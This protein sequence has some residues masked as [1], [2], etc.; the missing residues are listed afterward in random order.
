MPRRKVERMEASGRSLGIL[1]P[2]AVGSL[3]ASLD[4]IP[5]CSRRT[6]DPETGPASLG[7]LAKC[8]S[9]LVVPLFVLSFSFF[10]STLLALSYCPAVVSLRVVGSVNVAYLLAMLQFVTTFSVAIVYASIAKRVIDPLAAQTLT[11]IQQRA[12]R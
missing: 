4:D 9:R 8:R 10:L 1:R 12:G 7:T 6:R 2:G 5:N 3:D 11:Q